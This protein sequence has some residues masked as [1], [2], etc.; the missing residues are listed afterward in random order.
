[1]AIVLNKP[2]PEFE[3]LATG[4]IKFSPQNYLGKTVVLYFYPK[5]NTPGC[6]TEALQFRDKHK[7]LAKAGAVVFG[8]SRDNM[9][10]HEAFKKK[11]GLP[12]DLIA[13]T[14]EKLCHMFGV[15]KNKIMYGKK[16][17]GIQR[18][19]FL[20][21]TEGILR[22]EWRGLKVPG[23]VDEVLKAIKAIN[24]EAKSAA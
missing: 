20:I 13:D 23:H 1:M 12:F 7:E 2:L 16:V 4:G 10:S 21:D 9:Q 15:V 22:E 24:K 14:E 19:T 6:T 18:S 17:K 8:V 5:D 3:A 11:L